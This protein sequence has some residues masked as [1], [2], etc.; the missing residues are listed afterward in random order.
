MNAIVALALALG[1]LQ[2]AE[3]HAPVDFY[4]EIQPLIAVHCVRCHGAEKPKGGLRLT[5]REDALRGGASGEAAIVP[6]DSAR[7]RLFRLVTSTDADERMPRKGRPLAAREIDLLRRWIDQGASWPEKDDYWAF[8]PP[9][10]PAVKDPARAIDS[11]V[12]AKLESRGI[13][14]S[15]PASRE[16]LLRRVTFDLVG[17]PPSPEERDAFLADGATDAYE[18]VVDRLLAD[19]RHGERWARHWLDVARYAESDGFEND[20]I[21]PHAW[22]YRDYVVRS[23]ND[24]KPYD[25]FV[26]EQIAGDEL[27]PGDGDALIATGFSRLGAWDELCKNEKQRWQDYLNDATD[28]LGAAFLGLTLGCARCHDH[29]YDRVTMKDYYSLQAFLAG[30]RRDRKPL[31]GGGAD[32]EEVRKALAAAEASVVEAKRRMEDLRRKHA[33]AI[34][35]ERRKETRVGRLILVPDD[36]V[37][38][39]VDKLDKEARDRIDK[40]IK[41]RDVEADLYRPFAE[42]VFA[43]E[44]KPATRI[45]HRG[46]LGSPGAEV[47]PA[48]IDALGGGS[49]ATRG[50]LARWVASR[51]NP[52]TARVIVNRLWQHHF[53]R[54]LVGT[55]SDLGRNGDRPSHPELI[56]WLACEL[57]EGSWKLKRLHK[58]MVMSATYRQSSAPNEAAARLDPENRLLWRMNRRRLEGEAIRD[59]VLVASGRLNPKRG[60]PGVYAKIGKEVLIDLPNNDKLPSWGTAT[61]SEGCRRTI[62]VFQRRAL[63]LPIVEAFDGADMNNTCARRAVTTVAPQALSLFNGEFAREEAAHFARRLEGVEARE[64]VNLAWRIALSREPSPAELEAAAAFLEEQAARRL[65]AGAGTGGAPE[66]ARKEADRAALV[67]FCHV[68]LNTN[69]FVYVD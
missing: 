69:E 50:A 37:K 60:G 1:S 67:D 35:D 38:K 55:P 34:L 6:G 63:M 26:M 42:G 15:P 7:S 65:G 21:R 39:R 66:A 53:G 62:Y 17:V 23:L 3:R 47:Q 19:P 45:L 44:R 36:E 28:T 29:K 33:F 8:Q 20:K 30:S 27:W 59:A 22:R 51:E 46:E 14:P 49:G 11:L 61:E 68:L 24:D 32:P 18:R 12:L 56:D 57:M 58:L 2:E 41:A 54:G 48:F 10:R 43:S 5:R 40:E 31:P 64:R 52:T 9:R 4:G 25:R 13:A 16:T